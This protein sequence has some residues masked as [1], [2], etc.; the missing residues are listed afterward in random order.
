MEAAGV[1]Q[2]DNYQNFAKAFKVSDFRSVMQSAKANSSRL[3]SAAEFKRNDMSEGSPLHNTPL[4]AI[5]YAMMELGKDVDT[6]DVLAH[7]AM[8][9]PNYYAQGTRDLIV[10]LCQYL[11]T[12]LEAIRPDEA[13][14]A[15]VLAQS[16]RNQ[17]L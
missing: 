17:R 15:R 7:L 9:V 11:G 12:V 4:R 6:D 10:A 16:V 8:N 14:Q 1:S 3:K 13:S 5:L 2:L